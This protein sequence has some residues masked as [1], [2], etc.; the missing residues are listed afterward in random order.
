M[1]SDLSCADSTECKYIGFGAKPCGGFW[2]YLIYSSSNVDT[3]LLKEKVRKYNE[4]N[5]NLNSKYGW[6][7][8]CG[9]APIPI[10][11]C[12]EGECININPL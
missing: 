3:V 12:I 1:I 10:V 11:K 2:R 4:Y 9:L 8:D 6:I 5:R 7:S